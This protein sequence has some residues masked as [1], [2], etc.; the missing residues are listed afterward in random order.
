MSATE[1]DPFERGL[2][3]GGRFVMKLPLEVVACCRTSYADTF[4]EALDRGGSAA[5]LK[6]TELLDSEGLD[7]EVESSAV[8]RVDEGVDSLMA[9]NLTE[10]IDEVWNISYRIPS[11]V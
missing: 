3:F 11:L 10:R 2:H 9:A 6:V 7:G 5:V 8:E 4:T 1:R